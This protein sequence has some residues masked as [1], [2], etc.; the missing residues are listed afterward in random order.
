MPSGRTHDHITLYSLPIITVLAGWVVHSA[1]VALAVGAAYLFAG[2]MFGGDLD[3]RSHQ[4][5]RWLWLRW[6]WLPYRRSF[7]HRS[8]WTH[9]PIVGTG[10]RILYVFLWGLLPLGLIFG[11]GYVV[12]DWAWQPQVW[13]DRLYEWVMSPA[14][15]S[16]FVVWEIL[17]AVVIGL[18]LGAMSHSIS[19]WVGSTAKRWRRRGKS[20]AR[21]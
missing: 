17:L 19:D 11:V 10:V 12:W 3:T 2:L 6:M 20:G 21:R 14:G 18:E 7:K 4:Y 15:A 1:V 16:G 9:G 8:I 13:G 5:N